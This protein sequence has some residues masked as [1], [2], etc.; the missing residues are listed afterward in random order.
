MAIAGYVSLPVMTSVDAL[1]NGI[2][3]GRGL[4]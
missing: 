2:A 4:I 3:I 1:P